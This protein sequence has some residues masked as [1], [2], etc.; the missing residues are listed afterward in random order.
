MK[1]ARRL[2]S[3]SHKL[4]PENASSSVF[5]SK[6]ARKLPNDSSGSCVGPGQY[7]IALP[8]VKPKFEA[9]RKNNNTLIIKVN[10]KLSPVFQSIE[11]RF[12]DAKTSR[13]EEPS[14]EVYALLSRNNSQ[15]SLQKEDKMSIGMKNRL[16]RLAEIINIDQIKQR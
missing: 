10:E 5:K 14:N 1:E 6:I 13:E 7:N 2:F 3:K 12:K 4:S 16:K 11:P 9:I 15:D 8:I